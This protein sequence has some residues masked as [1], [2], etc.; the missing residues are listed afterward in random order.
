MV[1]EKI[2]VI[3]DTKKIFDT[4]HTAAYGVEGNIFGRWLS[5]QTLKN[6]TQFKGSGVLQ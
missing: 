4:L 3:K 6:S 2:L 5:W 1:A